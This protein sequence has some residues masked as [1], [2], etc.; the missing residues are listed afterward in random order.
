VLLDVDT[1]EVEPGPSLATPRL[2]GVALVESDGRV[3]LAGG[4]DVAGDPVALAERIDPLGGASQ[5]IG[6]VE[7]V[8]ARLASGAVVTAFSAGSPRDGVDVIP[9]GAP[10]ARPLAAAPVLRGGPTLTTLDDGSVLVVGGRAGDASTEAAVYSPTGQVFVDVLGTPFALREHAA[11]RLDDGT[12]LVVGGGDPFTSTAFADA[13]I[14]RPH[15][16]SS[17]S[18]LDLADAAQADLLSPRDPVRLR[19]E[20]VPP[21][22]RLEGSDGPADL[23]S[24]WAVVGG[25]SFVRPVVVLRGGVDGGG[26]AVLLGFESPQRYH[27]VALVPGERVELFE[28]RAGG[29]AD[30]GCVGDVLAAGALAIGAPMPRIEAR[31]TDDQLTVLV[32]DA[33]VADCHLDREVPRGLVGAGV[34]GDSSA[35]LVLESL[36]GVR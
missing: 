27:Y 11:I 25:P 21:R 18:S 36:V 32:G 2:D 7:G 12:V 8:P 22:Y 31:A 16:T 13:W 1:G 3:L 9:P 4:V 14:Y 6:L 33:T 5:G 17:F 29:R 34:I 30:T 35:E 26:L 19:R 20:T 15:L 28:V 24:E 23:P 10:T